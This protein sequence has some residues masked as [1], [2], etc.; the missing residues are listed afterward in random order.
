MDSLPEEVLLNIFLKLDQLSLLEACQ[1]TDSWSK[2]SLDPSLWRTV[3]AS[4][5]ALIANK[6]LM[7]NIQ[8][9]FAKVFGELSKLKVIG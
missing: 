6:D 4:W 2:V 1:V 9:F 3:D 7:A 5:P 8:K